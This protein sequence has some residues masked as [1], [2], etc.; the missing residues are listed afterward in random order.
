MKENVD[1][2]QIIL[3]IIQLKPV[4][5]KFQ[6]YYVC[7]LIRGKY[8]FFGKI[9]RSWRNMEIFKWK[10]MVLGA[11]GY[12]N[13]ANFEKKKLVNDNIVLGVFIICHT[14]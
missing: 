4:Y 8:F 6:S 13:N 2:K 11:L 1:S 9:D 7:G 10:W 12:K 5:L 14:Y 3:V